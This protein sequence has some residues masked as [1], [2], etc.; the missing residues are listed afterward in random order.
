MNKL[1]TQQFIL[2]RIVHLL[3]FKNKKNI[4]LYSTTLSIIVLYDIVLADSLF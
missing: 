3:Q 4:I 1:T 2:Q